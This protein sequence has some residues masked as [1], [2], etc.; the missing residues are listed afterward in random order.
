MKFDFCIEMPGSF[1]LLK[2][3]DELL[4]LLISLFESL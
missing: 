2:L 4:D 3:L 1:I